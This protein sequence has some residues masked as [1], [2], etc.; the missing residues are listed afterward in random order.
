[1]NE[2]WHE[3][4]R[5]FTELDAAL[6]EMIARHGAWTYAILFA[7]VF[8]ETGLVVTPFLPGDSLLFAAGA[9][10]AQGG[11]SVP[12]MMVLLFIAAVLGDAVNYHIGK[13]IGPPAF[14]GRFRFL[15]RSHLEKT[16][17]FF[18]KHGGKAIIYARFVPIVRTFAP[19]VAGVGTMSYGRFLAYNL[20][21]AFIWVVGFVGAG[22]V[23]GNIPW[24]KGNFSKVILGIIVV[25]VLPIAWEAL[26]AWRAARREGAKE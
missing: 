1:M 9:L 10:A 26:Q 12:L 17:R 6:A 20:I 18:E 25:S 23:F 16:Q 24:V 14:S 7:I 4:L 15:K 19:F 3:F 13:A 11:L 2:L 8:A 5:L 21:G 22:A